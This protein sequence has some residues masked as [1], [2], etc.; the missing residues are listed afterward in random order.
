MWA[1][2]AK[3]F[4]ATTKTRPA[5]KSSSAGSSWGGVG[6]VKATA[7]V[8]M[9]G[10]NNIDSPSNG[11][12]IDQDNSNNSSIQSNSNSE[13]SDIIADQPTSMAP[14]LKQR[15]GASN[16]APPPPY[17]SMKQTP[18][19][20]KVQKQYSV[21]SNPEDPYG[22][23]S[24]HFY[25]PRHSGA[26]RPVTSQSELLTSPVPV[27][28]GVDIHANVS[29]AY[30]TTTAVGVASPPTA[31]PTMVPAV[32]VPGNVSVSVSRQQQPQQAQQ[33]QLSGS[34]ADIR[35]ASNVRNN[36]LDRANRQFQSRTS[37][38]GQG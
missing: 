21:E 18:P 28:G 24:G 19:P 29:C 4:G 22:P 35:H 25:N 37:L 2:V 3:N 12:N 31:N 6:V 1:E 15:G 27:V 17:C 16:Q 32:S 14:I 38:H 10:L 11:Y 23:M 36:N 26:G 13:F 5:K 7:G 34:H 9:G 33:A 8:G 30:H 20:S